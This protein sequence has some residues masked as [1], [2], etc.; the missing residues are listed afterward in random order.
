MSQAMAPSAK[1]VNR[2]RMIVATMVMGVDPG[3]LPAVLAL[4]RT[5]KPSRP[6]RL[7]MDAVGTGL[8]LQVWCAD[9]CQSAWSPRA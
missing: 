4:V 1:P 2:K 8:G 7:L 9:L 5:N 6:H 3:A